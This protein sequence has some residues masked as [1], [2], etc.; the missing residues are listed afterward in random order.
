MCSI[1]PTVTVDLGACLI[2]S[3]T[4]NRFCI[5]SSG[6]QKSSLGKLVDSL[7]PESFYKAILTKP[8]GSMG[9]AA[10]ICYY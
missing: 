7:P 9:E 6:I 2:V 1:M 10:L 5:V 3:R 8:F 4:L